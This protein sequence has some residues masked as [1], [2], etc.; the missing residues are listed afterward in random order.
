MRVCMIGPGLDVTGGM[1]AVHRTWLKARA[2][3]GVEID[4]F[5]TMGPGSRLRKIRRMAAGEARF[6]AHLARGYRPDLFHIHVADRRSFLRKTAWYEQARRVGRPVVVHLHG[7]EI[8]PF[9]DA[10]RRNAALVSWLFERATLVLVLSHRS[11]ALAREWTGGRARVRVLYNPVVVEMFDP[12]AE[13]PVD[14]PATVLFMGAI[15]DRKGAF[16]LLSCVPALLD[17]HP[18][19]RFVF[20]GDGEVD[21]LKAEADRLGVSRAL[22]VPGWLRGERKIAAFLEADVFCLPSHHEN[23]PVAILEAMAA[24]LPV[25]STQ[26]AGIP[27]EVVEGETGLL[28]PPGD[29]AGLEAALDRLLGDPLSRHR[30]GAAGRARAEAVFDNEVVVERLKTL[31]GEA[32]DPGGTRS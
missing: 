22:E 23:L 12:P 32:L 9:H 5:E 25:I 3:E 2:M 10:S 24:R 15:G 28:V 18:G 27:E 20:G 11:E 21:R 8:E 31:W 7:A 19:T 6:L 17:R 29:R 4:Y 1:T 30:M 16:D 13:R 14:R 26:V